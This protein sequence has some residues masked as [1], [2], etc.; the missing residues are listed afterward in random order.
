MFF[1]SLLNARNLDLFDVSTMGTLFLV[2]AW[3]A[4]VLTFVYSMIIVFQTFFGKFQPDRL[5]KP[6]RE[7]SFKM[8]MAP[9]ILAVFV[10]G[11]FFFPN[12]IGNYL[13][14]PAMAAVYPS[15]TGIES[16]MPQ[17][18]AW[19]GFNPALWMT[20]G[21]VVL[22]IILYRF[23]RYWR[24]IYTI[25][26]L[27]WNLD[28]AFNANLGLLEKGS[29]FFTRLYMKGYLRDYLV[30]IFLFFI[31]AVGGALLYTGSFSIDFSNDA[32]ITAN[33]YLIVL[34][35]AGAGISILFAKS[36]MT[37]TIL[38]G[39]LGY[40]IAFFFVVF[41]A[42]DLALTQAIVE[43]VTTAL[44]LLCFYFLPEWKKESSPL[45]TK[46]LNGLIAFSVGTIVI[47][48]ALAVQGNKMFESISVYFEDSYRLAGGRNIVNT[49]LGDFRAF[50][51]MLEVVVLFIAG[52]GVY[53]L[54]KL[55]TR[56]EG[57]DFEDK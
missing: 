40:S 9:S 41:R 55:K 31:V 4:S 39:V 2:V 18:S 57:Q 33:E 27:K 8:L 45:R 30:Y 19:H 38:N 11:I 34:A 24:G 22:G 43:T 5:D 35:M 7:A 1:E 3:L 23:L 42:P 29:H 36:R 56:K 32:P 51:T 21:V 20:I 48:L 53:T 50:D 54:I 12:I 17:I 15:L 44:F 52:I 25:A 16:L 46:V 28:A 37:A 49:I 47:I 14:R 13:L 26:P 6:S 10:V